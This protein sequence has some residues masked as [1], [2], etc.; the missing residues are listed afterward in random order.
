MFSPSLDGSRRNRGGGQKVER[1]PPLF[2]K[3]GGGKPACCGSIRVDTCRIH[4]FAADSLEFEAGTATEDPRGLVNR[5]GLV[6][7]KNYGR[8]QEILTFPGSEPCPDRIY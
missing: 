3:L 5:P 7:D 4:V 1:I 2:P 8:L 6:H